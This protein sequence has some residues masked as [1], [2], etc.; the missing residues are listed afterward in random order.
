MLGNENNHQAKT[1]IQRGAS[2]RHFWHHGNS[3]IIGK[4]VIV[5]EEGPDNNPKAY[6]V[7]GSEPALALK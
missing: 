5:G 6:S 4:W 7:S 3:K 2:V 1:F